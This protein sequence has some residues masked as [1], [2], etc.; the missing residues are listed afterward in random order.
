MIKSFLDNDFYKVTMQ[1]AVLDHYPEVWVTYKFTN[2]NTNMKFN[3]AS[4][5]AIIE[6]V[7]AMAGLALTQDEFDFLNE[8]KFLGPTYLE[9]LRN[10]RFKPDQVCVKFLDGDLDI[11]IYGPWHETILWEVP[12]MAIISEAYFAHVDFSWATRPYCTKGGC[13]RIWQDMYTDLT[14]E[15]ANKLGR[16]TDKFTDFGTRRRRSYEA[17]DIVVRTFK[18]SGVC[19]FFGTSN[20]HFAHKYG[21][22]VVGTQAHEWIMGVSAL[23]SLRYAN[24]FA[25]QKWQE[26]YKGALGYALTDTFGT[27]AFFRDFNPQLAR[28]YDGVRHDSGCPFTFADKVIKNYETLGID[29]KTKLIVFSDGLDVEKALAISTH[30][31]GRI[32]CSFGIGTFF[33]NDFSGSKP[34]NMVIK[35]RDV[36]GIPVV[37]LSDDMKK[38]TG[39]K[40]AIRVALWTFMHKTLDA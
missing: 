23:E 22:K 37:K 38:A 13:G 10:F 28:V 36:S 19:N 40:D 11:E 34:L 3:G 2:R 27:D 33:T 5:N 35:L 12:L 18:E 1:R 9:Y 21:I 29:P 16:M 20:M 8:Y 15:K 14:I 25:L 6:N 4:Y 26:T 39:D 30:C 31:G 7:K 17:Q 32:R 24:K